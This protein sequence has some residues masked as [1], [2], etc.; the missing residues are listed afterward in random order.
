MQ[1]LNN[2]RQMIDKSRDDLMNEQRR[3]LAE[4]YEERRRVTAEKAEL[5]K[6]Q[7]KYNRNN[8]DKVS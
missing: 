1:Q 2:E 7:G 8:L 3:I 4:C 6:I 5:E